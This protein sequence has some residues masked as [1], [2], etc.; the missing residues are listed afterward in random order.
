MSEEKV[1]PPDDLSITDAELL[2]RRIPRADSTDVIVTDTQTGERRPSSGVFKS[3]D[4][5]GLSVYLKSVME[6]I[7]IGPQ[8]VVR[9]PNNAVCTVTAGAVR[10]NALGVL[11]D[12]NPD[13]V[14]DDDPAHPRHAAHGLITGPVHMTGG[15]QRRAARQLASAATMV[16]DPYA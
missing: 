6:Q 14:G 7:G 5:D 13:D 2:H 1:G 15:G 12:A 3:P 10:A 16:V 4:P 9:A 8:D 11:R